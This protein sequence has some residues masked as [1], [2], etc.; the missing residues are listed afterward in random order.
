MNGL[1]LDTHAWVWLLESPKRIPRRTLGAIG[2][3]QEDLV[4]VSGITLWE[5]AKLCSSGKL[6][7]S[8]S[9]RDW[10]CNAIERSSATV[11]PITPEIAAESCQ[12]PGGFH[13]DPADQMIV[14][15]ARV[16]GLDIVTADARIQ[17][18]PHVRS[19]WA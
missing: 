11:L 14:A 6:R 7:L 8:N 1:L 17:D 3:V 15:T 16:H 9:P 5:I 4:F 10:I 19:L 2:R 18:Y 12:L 13:A